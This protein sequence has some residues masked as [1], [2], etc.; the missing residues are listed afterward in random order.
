MNTSEKEKILQERSWPQLLPLFWK[1]K[2]NYK[3]PHNS[4]CARNIEFSS[5]AGV[6]GFLTV[7]HWCGCNRSCGTKWSWQTLNSIYGLFLQKTLSQ[8]NMYLS[9][10]IHL[11]KG[12]TLFRL[13]DLFGNFTFVCRH[14]FKRTF[15]I[16]ESKITQVLQQ[17]EYLQPVLDSPISRGRPLNKI[18]K[19]SIPSKNLI[20][21]Y[22]N[23]K[24]L[25]PIFVDLQQKKKRNIWLNLQVDLLF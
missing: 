9:N 21:G 16:S 7:K 10:L 13:Q 15:H 12:R 2:K 6:R 3:K 22:F 14:F 5:S 19:N 23:K 18:A 24:H 11:R 4:G 8:Q 17:K 20:L 25:F 1:L